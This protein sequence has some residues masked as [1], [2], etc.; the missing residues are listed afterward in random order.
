LAAWQAVC[1]SDQSF[2]LGLNVGDPCAR[3]SV[4]AGKALS[5]RSGMI[6]NTAEM[7][8]TLERRALMD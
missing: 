8:H 6:P 5:G 7:R 3:T 4:T 1:S 2:F